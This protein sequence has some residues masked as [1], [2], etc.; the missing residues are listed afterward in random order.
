MSDPTI[1]IIQLVQMLKEMS[2]SYKEKAR[3]ESNPVTKI[4]YTGYSLAY[5]A[6]GIALAREGVKAI[7]QGVGRN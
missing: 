2:E 3:A 7:K 1:S 5:K 6:L 4:L